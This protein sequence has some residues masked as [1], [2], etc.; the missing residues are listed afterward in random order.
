MKTPRNTFYSA[1]SKWGGIFI[2][3]VSALLYT[4]MGL[5]VHFSPLEIPSGELLF[6]RAIIAILVLAAV[7]GK[8]A[9]NLFQWDARPVWG[10]SIFG[11]AS[12]ICYYLTLRHTSF[13]NA[14]ILNDL[15]VI[16]VPI[17]SALFFKAAF[18]RL[19]VIGLIFVTFGLI[20]IHS[21][22]V[23]P[24][25]TETLVIGLV[26]AGIGAFAFIFLGEAAK[27]FRKSEIVFCQAIALAFCALCIPG[28]DWVLP[29]LNSIPFLVGSA[30][31]GLLAQ[32]ALTESYK[33]LSSTVA[34]A[35]TLTVVVWGLI[36][37]GLLSQSI[38]SATVVFIYM[39]TLTGIYCVQYPSLK[40]A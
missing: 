21:P 18:N 6:V 30:V 14:N 8:S 17:I 26:G 2:G 3:L 9:Q 20:G 15:G 19:E 29:T 34:T 4:M 40:K 12:I 36:L 38:P 31:L 7:L 39:I 5:L 33:L 1:S 25:S 10:R 22:E 11:A 37:E 28:K 13:G 27:R 24:M 35:L 23:E 16:F 32:L